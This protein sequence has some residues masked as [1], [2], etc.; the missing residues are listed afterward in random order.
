MNIKT[1]LHFAIGPI[2]AAVL[3]FITLPLTTWFF[4]SEDI[5]RISLLNVVVGLAVM[6]FSLG[7]DQAYVREYH[8]STNTPLL[9]KT[10]FLPGFLLLIALCFYGIVNAQF[11]SQVIFDIPSYWYGF[12]IIVCLISAYCVRFFSLILRMQER[13]LAF[14]FS[15]GPP[16][17]RG[18]QP[19]GRHLHY[20][21]QSAYR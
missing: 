8:E 12:G 19:A 20:H 2:G 6:F 3:G 7:L 16:I 9:W 11:L 21:I 14:S 13:G 15:H 5:G 18:S 17:H 10:C 4:S 1:V